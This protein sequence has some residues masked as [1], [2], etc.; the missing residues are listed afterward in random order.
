MKWKLVTERAFNFPI[1]EWVTCGEFKYSEE[2]GLKKRIIKDI[3]ITS[4]I[5]TNILFRENLWLSLNSVK[6]VFKC[7]DPKKFVN[8]DDNITI[9]N[10]KLWVLNE[11]SF[12][13]YNK[14]LE[15]IAFIPAEVPYITQ[16]KKNGKEKWKLYGS[17]KKYPGEK[18]SNMN[19]LIEK[20]GDINQKWIKIYESS[21][22]L[23]SKVQSSIPED[24]KDSLIGCKFSPNDDAVLVVF[25]PGSTKDVSIA[26]KS[27]MSSGFGVESSKYKGYLV[28]QVSENLKNESIEQNEKVKKTVPFS[29]FGMA[30]QNILI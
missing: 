2:Y 16:V 22:S 29:K 10:A 25:A 30:N 14:D 9:E 15:N 24:V 3:L 6:E 8:D 13:K 18:Y 7:D 21:S 20:C 28:L 4:S 11:Y 26:K 1:P 12:W 23:V 17:I 19:D 5:G 27:L